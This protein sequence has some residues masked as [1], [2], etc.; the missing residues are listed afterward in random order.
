[1]R[2]A[3]WL[4]VALLA[5]IAPSA[6]ADTIVVN[7]GGT[8]DGA[9]STNGSGP[10]ET[11][12]GGGDCTLRA[13]I[14]TANVNPGK[15]TITFDLDQILARLQPSTALPAI[16]EA[17]VIDGWSAPAA[18]PETGRPVVEIDGA[19]VP[20]SD[21]GSHGGS[22]RVVR[23]YGLD[24]RAPNSEIRGLAIH[25]FPTVQL[26]LTGADSTLVQ[27]NYLGLDS[28]GKDTLAMA[29][30]GL[31]VQNTIQATI[32]GATAKTRNTISGNWT[33][34][35]L[36]GSRSIANLVHGNYIGSDPSGLAVLGNEA[37]GVLVTANQ[38]LGAADNTLV[39]G[40]LI[41]GSDQAVRVIDAT[42]TSVFNNW[43]GL[44][45]TGLGTD[46]MG[47]SA[48]N[49]T[50]IDVL[51]AHDTLVGGGD[52]AWGT[53][54]PAARTAASPS[55]AP[56]RTRAS[57]AT[58]SGPTRPA[59]RRW[60][61]WVSRCARARRASPSSPTPTAI[62][63]CARRSAESRPPRATSAPAARSASA[64][65]AAW[66]TS[67]SSATSSARTCLGSRRCRTTSAS[68]SARTWDCRSR[69]S[70]CASARPATATSSPATSAA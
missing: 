33:G 58:S 18:N 34:V 65:S 51:S 68:R 8:L 53:S 13:A 61:T 16:T 64:C 43:I 54:S 4:A 66:R 38:V 40:N 42:K 2:R 48:G 32:G 47:N 14:Q 36:T 9:D 6:Y 17:V 55:A 10:C 28:L 19:K 35:L 23:P 70:T 45:A 69:R 59:A 26:G 57:R 62:T 37:N 63:R 49:T 7:Q 30:V 21:P 12:P 5:L 3:V 67:S 50:G 39:A 27:G 24:V 60:I 11:E 41:V 29:I 56:R 31:Y 44:T 15:D 52:E 1:M 22:I 46:A 25:G 20:I